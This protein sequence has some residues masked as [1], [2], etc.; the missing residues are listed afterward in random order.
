VS[1]T[2]STSPLWDKVA[3]SVAHELRNPLATIRVRI[4]MSQRAVSDGAVQQSCALVLEMK[5]GMLS[6]MWVF[7]RGNLERGAR[8]ILSAKVRCTVD[9]ARSV[10]YD[11]PVRRISIETVSDEGRRFELPLTIRRHSPER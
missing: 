5:T 10:Q 6:T 11:T 9:V 7:L 4:Q 1:P 2:K 8:C 3:A